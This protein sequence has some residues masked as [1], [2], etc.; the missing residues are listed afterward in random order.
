MYLPAKTQPY[1]NI[2]KSR[3]IHRMRQP[4]RSCTPILRPSAAYIASA[5]NARPRKTTK[6]PANAIAVSIG[7]HPEGRLLDQSRTQAND[8]HHDSLSRLIEDEVLTRN[9]G[10]CQLRQAIPRRLKV[11]GA[12]KPNSGSVRVFPEKIKGGYLHWPSSTAP[13]AGRQPF[14]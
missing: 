7:S 5:L 8:P 3:I 13:E 4:S 6:I 11:G 1:R 2:P 12:V 9:A 14:W 10:G